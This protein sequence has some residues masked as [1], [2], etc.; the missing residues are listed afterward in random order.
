MSI[1]ESTYAGTLSA[2]P[3]TTKTIHDVDFKV[4]GKT[5]D[6]ADKFEHFEVVQ[7]GFQNM[8]QM[9]MMA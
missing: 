1:R 4:T 7:A 5:A 3:G 8:D 2:V 9:T 6:Q